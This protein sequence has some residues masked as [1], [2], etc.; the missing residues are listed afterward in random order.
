MPGN[1]RI[2]GLLTGTDGNPASGL[3]NIGT[4]LR[5]PSGQVIRYLPAQNPALNGASYTLANMEGTVGAGGQ[6]K[7]VSRGTVVTFQ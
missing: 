7:P 5:V 3:G 2:T 6:L 4:S 1:S